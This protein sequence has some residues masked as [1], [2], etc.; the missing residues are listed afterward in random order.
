MTCSDFL[1]SIKK[2]LAFVRTLSEK[3]GGLS[4]VMRNRAVGDTLVVRRFPAPLAVYE[5]LKTVRFEN[6]PL[7]YDA[8]TLDDGYIV[9]EEYVDG[10]TVADVLEGGVYTYRGA[11]SVISSVCDALGVL[12]EKGFVHRDVK[13]ENI[14][15]SND[16]TVKL[17]DFNASRP[18]DPEK[19]SD[20]VTLGT[21]GYAP[22]EQYG[23]AQSDPRSDIYAL[24]V[25]L[26]VMLT[27]RHPS[28]LLA[29]GRAGKIVLKCTQIDPASRF[30]DVGEV[31][32]AL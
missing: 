17:I 9:F 18:V 12:H 20:T 16:G 26:N 7:I 6:L 13:P 31:K 32:N 22:P 30:R 29:P 24:G 3:N 23:I 4:V 14:I 28:D 8:V 11:K 1:E 19:R 2:D 5:Y 10:V 21:L 15:I 27:G 25:L